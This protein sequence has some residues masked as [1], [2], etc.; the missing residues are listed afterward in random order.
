MK[1]IICTTL[2]LLGLAALAAAQAGT[3]SGAGFQLSTSQRKAPPA[4]KTAEEGAAYQAID[5]T[6]DLAAAEA[7]ATD[8]EAKYPQSGLLSSI[9]QKLMYRYQQANNA[10]KTLAMG[11]KALQFDPDNPVVLVTVASVLAQRTKDTDLDRDQ[12]MA[13]T[14]KDAQHALDSMD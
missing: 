10:E 1:R 2:V 7:A 13:E 5:S 3:A 11:R 14:M 12:R 9:Y 6:A 4:A 8:F